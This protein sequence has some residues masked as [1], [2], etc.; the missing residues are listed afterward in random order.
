MPKALILVM[1]VS[2]PNLA[3]MPHLHGCVSGEVHCDPNAFK[4][5]TPTGPSAPFHLVA[6]NGRACSDA[7]T[8]QHH[9]GGKEDEKEEEEEEWQPHFKV[10]ASLLLVANLQM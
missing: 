9:R 1:L 10:Y 7:T 5:F 2:L 6:I 8:D 3:A 4:A